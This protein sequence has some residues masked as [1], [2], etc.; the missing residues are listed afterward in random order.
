VGS[1]A[2]AFTLS[3]PDG[4][5]VSLSDFASEKVIL[6]FFP[7]AMTP[8]CTV[9]AID[10]SAAFNSLDAAGYRVIGVS[11]DTPEKLA[12]FRDKHDVSF[13]ML[14]DPGRTALGAYGA[15]GKKVLYGKTFEGVIRSTFVIQLDNTGVGL[16][17][18]AQ[19]NV[20]ATGHVERL[21][22]ELGIMP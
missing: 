14:S 13:L 21:C 17:R 15:Y 2:P 18:L 16:I 19:Y 6:Y 11:P 8:G 7:A 9:E 10:F 4:K 12:E 20:R 22:R 1:T 5:Q 3:D